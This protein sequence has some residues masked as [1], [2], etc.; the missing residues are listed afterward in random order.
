MST[1][2]EPWRPYIPD[3]PSGLMTAAE[4]A[5]VF[6]VS[7]RTVSRWERS[8]RLISIRTPSGRRR[9]RIAEVRA[10]VA[11]QQRRAG[12]SAN[13]GSSADGNELPPA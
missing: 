4:V 10:L 5:A 6:R 3:H 9:Y 7:A 13:G 11:E 8:G 1:S 2:L 12:F